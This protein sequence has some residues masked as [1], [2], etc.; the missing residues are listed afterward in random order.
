[1]IAPT[2]CAVNWF[3]LASL[4][5]RDVISVRLGVKWLSVAPNIGRIRAGVEATADDMRRVRWRRM[6]GLRVPAWEFS[7]EV[8]RK[9]QRNRRNERESLSRQD[10][11]GTLISDIKS[12]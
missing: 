5:A 7:G 6:S 4:A 9:F 8:E 12:E 2:P 10:K 11:Y 3:I 1:M